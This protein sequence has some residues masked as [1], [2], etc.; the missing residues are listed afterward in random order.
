MATNLTSAVLTEIRAE[1]ARQRHRQADAARALNVTEAGISRRFHGR[2][3]LG[4]NE[5][6][7]LCDWLGVDPAEMIARSVRQAA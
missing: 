5:F 1:M 4:L 6:L 3:D 7:V 2:T